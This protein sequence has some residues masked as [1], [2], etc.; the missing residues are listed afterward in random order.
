MN[1]GDRRRAAKKKKWKKRTERNRWEGK[2]KGVVK[3]SREQKW[4]KGAL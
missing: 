3:N 1:Q 4:R 2:R